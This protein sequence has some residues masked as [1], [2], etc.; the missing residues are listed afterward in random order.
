MRLTALA[1]P[2]V[3]IRPP[4]ARELPI[5]CLWDIDREAPKAQTKRAERLELTGDMVVDE[6]RKIGFANM[7]DYMKSTP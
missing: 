5:F 7:A 2:T 1:N 3:S 6:L 4:P